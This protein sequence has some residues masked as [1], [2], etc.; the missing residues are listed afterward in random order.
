MTTSAPAV[1][2]QPPGSAAVVRVP[3]PTSGCL[4]RIRSRI[5]RVDQLLAPEG[6]VVR[7]L[8]DAVQQAPAARAPPPQDGPALE[9]ALQNKFQALKN[10]LSGHDMDAFAYSSSLAVGMWLA[11]LDGWS[12]T[13]PLDALPELE[14]QLEMASSPLFLHSLPAL[15][16]LALQQHG[17]DVWVV[18]QATAVQLIA[19]LSAERPHGEE[20]E[21]YSSHLHYVIEKAKDF[22]NRAL[23]EN[24]TSQ[25]AELIS[26]DGKGRPRLSGLREA[27]EL[28]ALG[29]RGYALACRAVH[30]L[31]HSEGGDAAQQHLPEGGMLTLAPFGVGL[32]AELRREIKARWQAQEEAKATAAAAATAATAAKNKA[33]KNKAPPSTKKSTPIDEK[34]AWKRPRRATTTPAHD[35]GT[36]DGKEE[37][38]EEEDN[39]DNSEDGD[40]EEEEEKPSPSRPKVHNGITLQHSSNSSGYMHVQKHNQFYWRAER[41]SKKK[42]DAWKWTGVNFNINGAWV[43]SYE[44]GCW[45]AAAE[46]LNNGRML[47]Q[48]EWSAHPKYKHVLDEAE[49]A[50]VIG[51]DA[52][53]LARGKIPRA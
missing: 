30:E 3:Q 49:A 6:A 22:M 39:D 17:Q 8:A 11:S 33:A 27:R 5:G 40:A 19:R 44:L 20:R 18:W 13:R 21:K 37:E 4:H 38:E 43:A 53:K 7:Q 28:L 2:A 42:S 10:R 24:P 35:R 15:H 25:L 16:P 29:P 34:K 50:G 46:A 48:Q 51:P 12:H 26:R 31:Q 14:E 45:L 36:T 47:S 1:S 41:A 23:D 52:L 32:P 9:A